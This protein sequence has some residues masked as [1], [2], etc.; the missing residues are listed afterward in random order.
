MAEYRG[1]CH[2]G[3][4]GYA[5]RTE[6]API[7]WPVRACQCTFCRSH[8]AMS[9]SDPYGSLEF[10]ADDR[11]ALNRYRFGLR[12]ADFL[13]CRK[14]GV[15]IGALIETDQGRFGIINTNALAEAPA[16]FA[17]ADPMDYDGEDAGARVSRRA[18]RWTPVRSSL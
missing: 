9:V 14:C 2:C 18:L 17:P 13:L 11:A 3:A 1:I 10:F 16:A 6:S 8:D 5:F 4:I 12:T 7:D 15:Y